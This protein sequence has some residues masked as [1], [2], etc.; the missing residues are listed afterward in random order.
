[1]DEG[2]PKTVV[3]FVLV[4]SVLDLSPIVERD[5]LPSLDIQVDRVHVHSASEAGVARPSV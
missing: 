2:A 5:C 1:M 3:E 4:R